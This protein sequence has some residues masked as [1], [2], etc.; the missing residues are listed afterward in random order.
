MSKNLQEHIF[1]N[2]NN[3]VTSVSNL[4]LD[5]WTGYLGTQDVTDTK[6]KKKKNL[7]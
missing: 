1:K 6:K 4:K 7:K 3:V 2:R 5:Q